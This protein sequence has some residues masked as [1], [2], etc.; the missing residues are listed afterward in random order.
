MEKNYSVL[1]TIRSTI[2]YFLLFLLIS[3]GVFYNSL[4]NEFAVV[5]DLSGYI[6]NETIRSIPQSITKLQMQEIVYALNYHFLK[7]NPTP[8]RIF[9]LFNHAITAYLIFL[10]IRSIFTHKIALVAS[11]LFLVHPVT[12]EAINWVSAQFYIVMAIIILLCILA[13]IAYRKTGE[14]KYIFIICSLFTFDI[15]FIRHA[16]VLIIPF[17]IFTFD[18]FFLEKRKHQ[19]FYTYFL[20]ISIPLIILFII[21]NFSG[22]FTQRMLSRSEPGKTL[23]NEQSLLPVLQ[24]YPYTVYSLVRLYSFPKDLTIYYDGTKITSKIYFLMYVVFVLYVGA[25]MYYWNK[26]KKI[27][28]LLVLLLI[29]ILPVF[30]PKKITW[31]ITERYL[32]LGTGFF[33][34]LIALFVFKLEQI[35]KIK[36][37]AFVLTVIVMLLYSIKTIHRNTEWKNPE[38]LAIATIKTSPYSV[39]PYNDI[40]GYYVL[41]QNYYKAKQYYVQALAVSS[42]LTAVRNLGHIYMETEF[43]PTIQTIPY[44]AD[45]IYNEALRMIQLQ[46]YYAAAYYL[47][48]ALSKSPENPDIYHRIA[49]LLV[50][51][52]R[53]NAAKK[54]I[55]QLIEKKLSNAD[56]FYILAFIFYSEQNYAEAQNYINQALQINP[57]H[58]NTLQLQSQIPIN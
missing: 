3:F 58:T 35:S 9:A 45:Q 46:E 48:E 7:I 42:S 13:L 38:T 51:Y 33:T 11:M 44:P 34:T 18:Y 52:E 54:Y 32:Y 16:W 53:P 4:Q 15:I 8:L 40:A 41:Q 28:G 30:S 10:I 57:N 55:H 31:F 20:G 24:G 56:S 39:R 5:D 37:L 22:A 6:E 50:M 23:Q 1:T 12:T 17:V 47:N 43:D 25:I 49:E 36:Y 14:K 2:G 21:F 27:T 29:F 26:N 19:K